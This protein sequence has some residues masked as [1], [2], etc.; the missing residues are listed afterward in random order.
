MHNNSRS[1]WELGEKVDQIVFSI[2]RRSLPAHNTKNVRPLIV[3]NFLPSGA[4][5]QPV[6][7][8]ACATWEN[9]LIE[10]VCRDLQL[11]LQLFWIRVRF[12]MDIVL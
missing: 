12:N 5:Y 8:E 4:L 9:D 3:S 1:L 10:F 7:V 11:F 6:P 2:K